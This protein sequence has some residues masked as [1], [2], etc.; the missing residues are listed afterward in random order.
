MWKRCQ[1]GFTLLEMIVVLVIL[2]L[3]LSLLITRG[4]MHSARL[5]AEVAARD[6]KGALRLARGRAISADRHVDVELSAKSYRV[7]GLAPHAVPADVTL[8][9][10]SAIGFAPDGSSSGGTIEVQG[11]TSRITV[12]VDWLT[13][14]VRL[15]QEP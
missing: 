4:P 8:V 13:G 5:D 9:G 3:A 10:N 7:D 14:R 2:G 12:A 6:L 15:D 1:R 11:T